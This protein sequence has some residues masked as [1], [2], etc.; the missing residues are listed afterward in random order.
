M[1]DSSPP[2]DSSVADSSI[3]S[4]TR[5]AVKSPAGLSTPPTAGPG[6]A[7]KIAVVDY[8]MGNLH[9]ACKALALAGARTEIT[10]DPAVMADAEAVVLPGV[11]AFDPAM[12]HLGDR[13]LI[14]PLRDIAASGKPFL[15]ICV[16]MQLLFESSEEGEAEGLGIVPGTVRRFQ[17]EPGLTIPHMGWNQLT[18]TQ[19]ESV[20]LAGLT[21][22]QQANAWVYFV[23]SFYAE[24]RHEAVNAAVVKHGSQQV[25]AAIAQGNVVATQFH[26]EKS[27]TVGL[28]ILANFVASL[29]PR[30]S[31]AP[32]AA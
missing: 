12:Q 7:P 20:I 15:G 31:G 17:S 26:P 27:S 4:S 21:P 2:A 30:V 8:D 25:T 24:P 11:G 6:I 22:E 16:G 10:A 28:Q 3:K 23:H 14:Q 5:V 13:D 29:S 19:P 32:I 1:S 9:S 18:F